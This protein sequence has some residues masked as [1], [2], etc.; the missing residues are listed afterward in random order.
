MDDPRTQRWFRRARREMYPRL[1]DS[2]TFLSI[3][4]P[5]DH[6]PDPQFCL[7][8]GAAI[9]MGKPI[10]AI[11]PAG[12]T[13]PPGLRRVA[14]TVVE[15]VDITSEDDQARVQAAVVAMLADQE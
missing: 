1:R 15:G 5:D 3:C 9:M 8:L 14:H 2:A 7:E 10:L 6:D 12:R 13:C 4:P 11:V